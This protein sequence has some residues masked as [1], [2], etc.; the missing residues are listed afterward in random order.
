MLAAVISGCTSRSWPAAMANPSTNAIPVALKSNA[1]VLPR[2]AAAKTIQA[3]PVRLPD[4]NANW[5]TPCY[6]IVEIITLTN[7]TT[8]C[9]FHNGSAPISFI[10]PVHASGDTVGIKSFQQ[11][12]SS[13]RITVDDPY[14]NAYSQCALWGTTNFLSWSQ[15][16]SQRAFQSMMPDGSSPWMIQLFDRT[17]QPQMFYCVTKQ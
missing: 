9:K 2:V 5:G 6:G 15:L 11:V 4:T 7:G 16:D 1:A 12:G 3:I 14:I 13:M 10:N 8:A 17:Q